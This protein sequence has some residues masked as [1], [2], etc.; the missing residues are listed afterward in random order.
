MVASEKLASVNVTVILTY[1]LI[2]TLNVILILIHLIFR[3]MLI[4]LIFILNVI[5]I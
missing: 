4:Y 5:L 2:F 1:F 3:L